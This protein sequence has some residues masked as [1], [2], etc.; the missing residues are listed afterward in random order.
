MAGRKKR[1]VHGSLRGERKRK[2][3][4]KKI[5]FSSKTHPKS[6]ILSVVFGGV[7]LITLLVMFF[8]SG[9]AKGT[10]GSWIGV[11]GFWIFVMS[12]VGF[13]LA[14]RSY[15]NED[16]YMVTPT[17]GSIVNGVVVVAM[18]LLYV[19]GTVYA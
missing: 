11:V 16:I 3:K 13:I 2:L 7:A 6:G 9:V 4:Q 14:I 5:Q 10:S 1:S 17:I 15:R 12:V 18:M 19:I 8:I